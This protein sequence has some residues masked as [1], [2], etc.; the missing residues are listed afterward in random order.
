MSNGGDC[1]EV[2]CIVDDRYQP[3]Q[4]DDHPTVEQQSPV[5]MVA[6]ELQLDDGKVGPHLATHL[7]EGPSKI[8]KN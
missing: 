7:Y 2:D 8:G 4:L 6:H 1:G 5:A 3:W